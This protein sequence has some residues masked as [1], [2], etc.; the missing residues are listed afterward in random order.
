[1]TP[2]AVTDDALRLFPIEVQDN[3]G[4]SLEDVVLEAMAD[5]EHGVCPVCGGSLGPVAG[6]VRCG[7]CGSEILA[8]AEPAPAWVA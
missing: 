8:G 5:S 2:A 1:M 4:R 3:R 7:A 6:G